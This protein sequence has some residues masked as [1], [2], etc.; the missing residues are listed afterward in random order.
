M[1]KFLTFGLALAMIIPCVF[2]AT[3]CSG[4]GGGILGGGIFGGGAPSPSSISE[5]Y[6]K[7]S[8]A[9]IEF[10]NDFLKEK[11]EEEYGV[12]YK[13]D[14]NHMM[15]TFYGSFIFKFNLF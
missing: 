10:E 14:F 15:E 9:Q 5:G 2:M 7:W 6:Y 1:K 11:C 12:S 8:D 4:L 3:G 13:D